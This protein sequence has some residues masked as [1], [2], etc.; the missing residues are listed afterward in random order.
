MRDGDVRLFWIKRRD[1]MCFGQDWQ[2]K[3]AS[4]LDGRAIPPESYA[5]YSFLRS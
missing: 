5:Q 3:I 4:A 1:L 2:A